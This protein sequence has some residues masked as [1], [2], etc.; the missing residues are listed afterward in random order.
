[1]S[2]IYDVAVVGA[3][4]AG[5]LL[6]GELSAKRP[7]LRILLI[8]GQSEMRKKPCG[9]LLAPDA[10][11]FFA[12]LDMTLP[13]SILADPQ[14]FTVE[15]IDLVS[16][17][18]R[19]Y[20]R[21][22]LNMDRYRFD[23]WLLSLVPE[24][25]DVIQDRVFSIE[26]SNGCFSLRLSDST[27]TARLLVGAD[28]SRSTVRNFLGKESPKQYIS[29]QEW[30]NST[31]AALPYYSCIFDPKTS[32]S[33]SWTIHKDGQMIYGGAF[34]R[35]GC[36]KA[37]DEQKSRF[38]K[39]L[40][41]SLGQPIRSEACLVSSPR[42]FRDLFCGEENV[43]LVGEAA[44]FISASSFE[45]ISSALIS[46]RKAAKAIAEHMEE[47]KKLIKAYKRL[48]FS[49]RIKLC[50]KMLKRKIL[51]TPLL[52]YIIMKSGIQSI[53]TRRYAKKIKADLR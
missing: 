39:F 50:T 21:H 25:V 29:I 28:G 31:G 3:G 23:L 7:E 37:F 15:T 9:G 48:T 8:N 30:Y 19:C 11:R 53:K 12:E 45:G 18:V 2:D 51:F 27:V 4:P 42:R 46:A 26:K 6:A 22:Y 1:M 17:Q 24:T 41:A 38:E 20:Q 36:R 47:P 16:G 10:Q 13:S 52:R 44:G 14:I 5:A 35:E 40:G 32:S 34:E 43:L 49:L 33:C